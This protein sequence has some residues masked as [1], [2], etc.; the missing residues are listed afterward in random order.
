M[1]CLPNVH[2]LAAKA[3][4]DLRGYLAGL[5]AVYLPYVLDDFTSRIYPA[6]I[7]ECLA[8]GLPVVATALPCC[9]RSLLSKII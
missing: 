2:W 4:E 8:L 7:H 5:N 6:K 3:H 9:R 1:K